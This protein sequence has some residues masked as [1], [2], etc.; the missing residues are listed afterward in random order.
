MRLGGP[1]QDE[2]KHSLTIIQHPS[3][4]NYDNA[5]FACLQNG[6]ML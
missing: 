2:C 3:E 1:K 4:K 6:S 5:F